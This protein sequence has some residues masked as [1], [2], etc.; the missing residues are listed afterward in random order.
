MDAVE[1]VG[2]VDTL[3]IAERLHLRLEALENRLKGRR[4]A[5]DRDMASI[6]LWRAS[7]NKQDS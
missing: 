4:A 2:N 5:E 3:L 7:V 6:R 1:I